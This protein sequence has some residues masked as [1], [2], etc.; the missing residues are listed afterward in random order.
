MKN[1]YQGPVYDG[2]IYSLLFDRLLAGLHRKV[3]TAVDEGSSCLDACCGTGGLSFQLAKRCSTVVGVDISEKMVRRV[4]QL[5]QQR[6][7]DNLSFQIRDVSDLEGIA[8]GAFDF[9]TVSMGLHEM[10]AEVRSQVLPELLRIAGKVVIVDFAVPMPRNGAGLRNRVIERLAG[11][12]HY[13]GFRDYYSRGGLPEL[14]EKSGGRIIKQRLLDNGT[15]AL[16]EVS[17]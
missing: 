7:V 13:A 12:K 11:S 14:I 9:A 3:A 16:V 8:D 6:N 10:P 1:G 17:P 5:R 15:L 2:L 4:E